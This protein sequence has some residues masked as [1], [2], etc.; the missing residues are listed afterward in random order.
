M[1]A[2]VAMACATDASPFH[3]N[4]GCR[5]L[6]PD[7]TALAERV[8]ARAGRYSSPLKAAVK[9]PSG[10]TTV[11]ILLAY[12]LS[13]QKWLAANGGY[14]PDTHAKK[15]IDE[16]N[17]CL[18]NS[19]VDEFTFR[20]AGTMCFNTDATQFRDRYGYVDF[21]NILTN[22]LV[23]TSGYSV[24]QGEWAKVVNT[25]ENLGADIVCVAIDSGP[26]GLI[27]LSYA[28]E[29]STAGEYS[30]Y[31]LEIASFGDWAY[32]L[33]SIGAAEDG[34]NMV[35]EVGH[36]M[37]C[38]HPDGRYA[39]EAAIGILGP[40]LYPYSAGV[41]F[42]IGDEGYCTIMGYNFGGLRP[43]GTFDYE[44]RFTVLPYFSSPLLAYEGVPLGSG[45]NDNRR[46]LLGTYAYAAQYRSPPDESKKVPDQHENSG[47]EFRPSKAI[48]GTPYVGAI[49]QNGTPVGVVSL[50]CA[51]EAT[52]GKTAGTSKVVATV[53]GLD[54]KKS[55][56]PAVYVTCGYNAEAKFNVKGWGAFTLNLDGEG[57]SGTLGNDRQVISASV[58]GL[59]QDG[60]YGASIDAGAANLPAG[61]LQDLL[62]TAAKPER[63]SAY[64]GKWTFAKPAPVKYKKT[65][66]KTTGAISYQ[67]QGTNDTVN[68]NLS[69]MKL[70][71]AYKTGVFKGSFK[72]YS[73]VNS[74]LKKHT[75]KISGFVV[76]SVGYGTATINRTTTFPVTI[77]A[78]QNEDDK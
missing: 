60:R 7:P 69:A 37:G 45:V 27:G 59:L 39:A 50:K 28:L 58:G 1:F 9:A 43:D 21:E 78:L 63:F 11:D 73:L 75:A 57:L 70:T 24:A 41:Y 25:R 46:T 71:Y 26:Y 14:T 15:R 20:L 31:P 35:H 22:K 13:A 76:D 64:G 8:A 34:L 61:T 53:T 38:G 55:K 51:K 68:A 36:S 4:T 44:D 2:T 30:Q 10:A 5:T 16:M 12:D 48:N 47:T 17:V 19:R 54:G 56:S 66:D 49:M 18:A 67:L 6:R 33:F 40:Q 74:K 42:W 77:S 23:N 65:K 32:C 62:P 52:R 29:D 3:C 72:A